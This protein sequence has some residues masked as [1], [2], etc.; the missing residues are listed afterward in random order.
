MKV[1]LSDEQI[2][3]LNQLTKLAVV[4][5][6]MNMYLTEYYKENV[7][8]LKPKRK[9][10]IKFIVEKSVPYMKQVDT[11]LADIRRQINEPKS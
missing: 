1:D 3:I 7:S 10:N 8:S 5:D 9:A 6:L 11:V 4:A 2:K